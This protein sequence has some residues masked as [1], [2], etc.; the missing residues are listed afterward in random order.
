M[1]AWWISPTVMEQLSL[2]FRSDLREA[3]TTTEGPDPEQDKVGE[4][5]I[6]GSGPIYS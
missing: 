3:K 4:S 2:G 6:G 1:M 5:G